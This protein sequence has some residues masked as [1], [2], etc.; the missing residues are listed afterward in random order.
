MLEEEC[1]AGKV[2][3]YGVATWNGLRVPPEENE[4]LGLA[5]LVEIAAEARRE[6]GLQGGHH[7]G[8]VQAPLNLAMTESLTAPTQPLGGK[9]VP[10]LDAAQAL[11][12]G[13]MCS[14]SILQGRLTRGLPGWVG[15]VLGLEQDAHRALQ[16]TRSAPGVTSALVGL[17][18]TEHAEQTLALAKTEPASADDVRLLFEAAQRGK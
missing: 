13:V 15:G 10:L 2:G 7:F 11:G 3:C 1:D 18:R 5:R 12:I 6:A 8:V 9:R 16:F 14:A 17:G 4:H